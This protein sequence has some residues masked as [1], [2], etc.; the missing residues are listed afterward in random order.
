VGR[1]EWEKNARAELE[2]AEEWCR[3]HESL[4]NANNNSLEAKAQLSYGPYH[5]CRLAKLLRDLLD[6]P[7]NPPIADP[8]APA[9]G[10]R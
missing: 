6:D 2:Q 4:F 5:V 7:I 10:D 1:N 9:I 8:P 3:N